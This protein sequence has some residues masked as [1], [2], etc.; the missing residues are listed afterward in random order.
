MIKNYL[1]IAFR[2]LSRHKVFTTIQ[3]FGF[4]VGLATC[5]LITLFVRD[6]L[7]YDRYNTKADRI[8]RVNADFKLNGEVLNERLSPAPL[9]PALTAGF[10]YIEKTLRIAREGTL[11]VNKGQEVIPEPNT[12]FADS[13]FFDVFSL[14]VLAGDP[15]TA[16]TEPQSMVITGTIAHKYFPGI[17]LTD[18]PG[19][20]LLTDKKTN[21][22]ITAVIADLPAQSHIHYN[23]IMSMAGIR[24][25]R[26]NNW[27]DNPYVTYILARE[28]T[29][30]QQ[31]ETALNAVTVKYAIPQLAAGLNT[32]FDDLTKKGVR[33]RYTVT[34][35][36]AIH[37]HSTLAR[38]AE[39]SGNIQY[40]YIFT[41]TAIII[42]LLACI[43]F[44]NLS[45]ARSADRSR[46]VGVRKVLGS[47]R[48]SLVLQFL[49][50]SVLISLA[51]AVLAILLVILLMPYF[52][53]VS[54]KSFTAR[55]LFTLQI[56][57]G[58]SLTALFTGILAGS[59]PAIFLSSFRPVQVLKG[60]LATGF[61]GSWLRNSMVVFQ[62][63]AAII[64]ITGTL[65]IY[66]Q[67]NYIR[68]K[69][70]GYNRDQVLLV[71]HT[72]LLG[73]HARMFTDAAQK[74]PGVE[75]VTMA[76]VLPTAN[77]THTDIFFK[78][79]TANAN[80]TI[81][82]EAWYVDAGFIPTLQIKM[83]RGR[84]FSPDMPTDS[85]AVLINE[86]A[87]R[88][89]GYS[90]PLNKNVYTGGEED[91]K[92]I[93]HPVIGVVKDF[94]A[95]SLRN[96]IP[97]IIF[98]LSDE[99]SNMAFRIDPKKASAVIASLEKLYHT[100]PG[101][102]GQTF[103]YTFMDEDFNRLYQSE[104][105]TG[106]IFIGFAVL[107]IAIAC[108]GLFGLITYAAERRTKEI[109]IRK[110]LGADISNIV[111]LLSVDFIKLVCISAVIAFPVAW[112]AMHQWLQHFAYRT[113]ISIWV[114]IIAG[115]TAILLTLVTI[116]FRAI[117]A[118]MANP[119]N[120]LRTE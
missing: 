22:R 70:L 112:W 60:K 111:S 71:Q 20:T 94:N 19:K 118:A 3:V 81:S 44:M 40:I 87:A 12:C 90:D 117:R 11:L 16:L 57:S 46:E 82:L 99:R 5:L 84:N 63:T 43:N 9:A 42:L 89:L 88:M 67:L 55:N 76:D 23:F 102:A 110:V 26:N 8:Y 39:P 108:L 65:V 37:L 109:G 49:T 18:I 14:S 10:P 93:A 21:Y 101:M 113:Q 74:L 100:V 32:T 68:N 34:P 64:L 120:S 72:D 38:E 96:T 13:T 75:G 1:K 119:V 29:K 4:A 69:K 104:Q 80:N 25:S 17:A 61:K 30:Q 24:D 6:E 107:A 59:Y 45:T 114:F 31:V 103:S 15:K 53:S 91:G 50:E 116:S 79:A 27:L 95:G 33:Y 48:F 78:D 51:A 36:T 58:L 83:A 2:H 7:S 105:Q 54:G 56:L 35:L 47:Q 85:A 41:I 92:A 97:P 62:F 52:N 106:K 98:T 86:T 115:V 28:G 73:V 77:E 66:S